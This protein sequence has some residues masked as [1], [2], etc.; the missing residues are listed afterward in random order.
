MTVHRLRRAVLTVAVAAGTF[1]ASSPS[2]STVPTV[3]HRHGANHGEAVARCHGVPATIVGNRRGNKI[4]GSR[5]R[6]VI[7]GGGGNDAGPAEHAFTP[8][9]HRV[10]DVGATAT[11]DVVTPCPPNDDI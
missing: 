8:A 2:S 11:A 3:A 7:V 5:H 6:D 9:L 4:V 10:Q 1:A